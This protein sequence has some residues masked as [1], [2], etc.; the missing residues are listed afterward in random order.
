MG[1]Y[2]SCPAKT[3][4]LTNCKSPRCSALGSL[5][6][7]LPNLSCCAAL[8]QR[9]PGLG[10]QREG[11]EQSDRVEPRCCRLRRRRDLVR[12]FLLSIVPQLGSSACS[13]HREGKACGR[14]GCGRPSPTAAAT[15]DSTASCQTERRRRQRRRRRR[16]SM[17]RARGAI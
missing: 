8:S 10:R 9:T 4:M 3:W 15:F 1:Y 12:N 6:T 14:A 5:V 17:W 2:G 16:C 11:T 7:T 13:G